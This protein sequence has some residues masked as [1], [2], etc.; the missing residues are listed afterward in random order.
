MSGEAWREAR[1]PQHGAET[2]SRLP[3][4]L[5]L[6]SFGLRFHYRRRRDFDVFSFIDLAAQL[7]FSGVNISAFPPRYE[8]LSGGDPEHLRAVRDRLRAHRLRLD[9]EMAGTSAT[10]LRRAVELAQRLGAEHIRTYT[11]PERKGTER[12]VR[13]AIHGLRAAAPFAARAGVRILVENHE[14]LS[15]AFVRRIL[16][17][18]DHPSIGV[19]FDYGNSMIFMEEP[20][21]AL[22]ELAPWIMSAHMKDHAVLPAGSAGNRPIIVGVPLGDG[23]VPIVE[24]T[25]RLLETG[26]RR[27]C[28]E[29]CWGYATKFRA[30]RG[31]GVLGAGTFAYLAGPYDVRSCLPDADTRGDD[32]TLD[33]VE[34]EAEALT[35]QLCWLRDACAISGIPLARE[36]RVPESL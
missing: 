13:D 6:H 30:R 2:A 5:F 15:A 19:L 35:R 3:L 20:M 28:F 29:N 18:T 4:E 9:I 21:T 36:L 27:I 16:V 11:Y 1:P 14:D 25:R 31:D 17:E 8:F 33:L 32:Q 12:Q 23:S 26:V 10:A 34:L 22:T 24:L 7:G